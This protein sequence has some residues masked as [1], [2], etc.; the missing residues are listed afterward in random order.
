MNESE[1]EG[2]QPGMNLHD[3]LFILF[4]HKWKILICAAI[5]FA[6]AAAVF[7]LY[8]PLYESEAK[9][10]VRYV[11]DRSNI[12]AVDSKRGAAAAASYDD[13]IINS[14][15][16]IL[17]SW[18]LA[19]E[20]AEVV[21]AENA[22]VPDAAKA[23]APAL[24]GKIL[25]NLTVAPRKGSN[26]ILISYKDASPFQ[27]NRILQELVKRYYDKHLKVH[28]SVGSFEFNEE[29]DKARAKLKETEDK[30][31]E[32]KAKSGIISLTDSTAGLT[33][34][35]ARSDDEYHTAETE[36]R[37]QTARV[38]ALQSMLFGTAP[39]DAQKKPESGA[40]TEGGAGV[41]VI[42]RPTQL[43]QAIR[44]ADA[45]QVLV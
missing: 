40:T 4:K 12:D 10:M 25:E 29:I 1:L 16:E 27:A 42:G 18:D 2:S 26:V 43:A 28:R 33:G 31:K 38:Q 20:V 17:T 13:T 30:L 41:P 21:S 35:I 9:L 37:E 23:Q 44:A 3:I 19:L 5:G 22:S 45:N 11:V 32:M 36:L 8:K 15:I 34:A 39:K 6:A 7:F 14:E 24:A